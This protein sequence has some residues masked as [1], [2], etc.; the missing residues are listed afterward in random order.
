ME[1]LKLSSEMRLE[2]NK[3]KNGTPPIYIT[4]RALNEN[5]L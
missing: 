1:E 4:S 3:N 2:K 5:L